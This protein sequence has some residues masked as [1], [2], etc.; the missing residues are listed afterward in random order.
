MSLQNL[1]LGI[2]TTNNN[3]CYALMDGDV[4]DFSDNQYPCSNAAEI[5]GVVIKESLDKNNIDIKD[6]RTII[7][8]TGPGGFSGVR[9]GTSFVTGFACHRH[10]N[11]IPITSLQAAAY[12]VTDTFPDVVIIA[13]L[14]ARRNGVYISAFD[15]AYNRLTEDK[16][17]DNQDIPQ[18]LEPF[19]DKK[20]IL[21]GHG[22]SIISPFL[23]N[24]QICQK[25]LDYP[26]AERFT[27]LAHSK[28]CLDRHRPLYL[29][30][31]DAKLPDMHV[32]NAN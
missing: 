15:S 32:K 5:L 4:V 27:K 29:R 26:L 25:P 19:K 8:V 2:D 1:R 3:L 24:H 31:P 16:V 12:S 10:I 20:I 18:F 11:I 7:S 6:I 22:H 23:E 17:I 14:N 13:C 28:D 21:S 30:E 9:I